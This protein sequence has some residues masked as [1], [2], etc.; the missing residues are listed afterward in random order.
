MPAC[1]AAQQLK[2]GLPWLSEA[3]KLTEILRRLGVHRAVGGRGRRVGVIG[4]VPGEVPRGAVR[5]GGGYLVRREFGPG[6]GVAEV[7]RVSLVWI[8]S[9]CLGAASARRRSGRVY[10]VWELNQHVRLAVRVCAIRVPGAPCS[11]SRREVEQPSGLRHT[12]TRSTDGHFLFITR[13]L[14]GPN[15]P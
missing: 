3:A 2:R 12:S 15:S 6:E 14:R 13:R 10:T 5:D 9:A 4:G 8:V 11:S 7:I 1:A